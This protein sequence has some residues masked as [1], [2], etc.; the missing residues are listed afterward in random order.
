[1]NPSYSPRPANVEDYE[2]MAAALKLA[3]RGQYTTS[4]NPRVGCIIVDK[5]NNIVG[6]G[7]HVQA[8]TPHAEVH[9]LREAGA[10]A[11]GATAYV[12]LEPCSHHGRTPPCAEA[13]VAAKVRRVVVAMTDPNPQ[14]SGRGIRGLEQAGIEV[15]TDV[16]A[17][18]A[19]RLNRGFIKRMVAGKPWVTVKLATS[20]DGKIALRNGVSQWITGAQARRDVQQHRAQSC[21][22]LTGSGTALA[23]NPSLLVRAEEARF[24]DY[25]LDA[26]RQPVR[27]VLDSHNRLPSDLAL[28]ND[29]EAT[30]R[31]TG[32]LQGPDSSTPVMSVAM[33]N[34]HIDLNALCVK[35]GQAQ[36]NEVW[37]EAGPELAGAML[38]AGE[39]DELIV[40]QAARMLG[41]K[42]RSM[43]TLPDYTRLESAPSLSLTDL[44][45]VGDDVKMTY[46]V[47]KT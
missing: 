38:Q 23:D 26:I 16:M 30:I 22:I 35:L 15:I 10:R 3:K 47:S 4:P 41:D 44:R 20:I 37:V 1:M 45:Q 42:G 34:G 31:V 40:Y 6:Q 39:V 12:T 25:P 43:M 13:L 8:G 21:A 36:F 29:S 11:Q 28:F 9:A 33:K 7:F 19:S 17:A 14:V 46:T 32:Q 24:T 2:W 5:H 27:L 18:E